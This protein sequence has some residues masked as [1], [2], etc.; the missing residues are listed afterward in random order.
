MMLQQTLERCGLWLSRQA[1][2]TLLTIAIFLGITVGFWTAPS[3]RS[4]TS[5]NGA[6]GRGADGAFV[7]CSQ[8]SIDLLA[9][10][11]GTQLKRLLRA[12]DAYIVYGPDEFGEFQLRFKVD[13]REA[14]LAQLRASPGVSRVTNFPDCP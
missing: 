9:E 6:A 14:A 4:T 1:L 5:K 10:L 2:F 3:A 7:A 13:R 12:S 11:T 8:A